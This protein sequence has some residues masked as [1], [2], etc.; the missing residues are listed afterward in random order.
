MSE[1]FHASDLIHSY[2]RAEAIADG[3]LVALGEELGVDQVFTLDRKGFSTYRLLGRK[4]F[5]IL[6]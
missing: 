1:L 2:T 4:P 3:T 6:P 5:R